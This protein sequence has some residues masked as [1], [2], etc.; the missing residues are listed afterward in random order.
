MAINTSSMK[1]MR[2]TMSLHQ[3]EVLKELKEQ[4]LKLQTEEEKI[5]LEI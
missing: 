1:Y 3:N 5:L 2:E 4:Q